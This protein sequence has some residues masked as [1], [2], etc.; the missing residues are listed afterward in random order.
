MALY[1]GMDRPA[2]DGAYNNAAAVA[3]SG[4]F[5]ADWKRRSAL[6]RERAWAHLNLPYG[7]APSAKIDFF[8]AG[9]P[10]AATLLFFHG[11]YWQSNSREGFAFVAE[12][13]LAH[14]INVAVVGYTL[15]PEARMDRIV[16][17]ARAAACWLRAHLGEL[18]GDPARL[19]ASG[20]SAGGHLAVTVMSDRAACGGLAISG[21]YDLEPIRLNYLNDKLGLD[22]AE[23]ERNSPLLHLP[24]KAGPLLIAVGGDELPEL[25][26][27][28]RDFAAAWVARGLPGSFRE[29]PGRHH[30]SVLEELA[31]P[32]GI[33]TRALV[34][35]VG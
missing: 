7:P 3:A 19:F 27:Q 18:G 32:G 15:A 6:M 9:R 1:R 35:L 28:S 5:L 34:D 26:R 11:G 33:L 31:R 25:R 17:E 21:I 12:G 22:A 16:R 4:D 30:F 20:W 24:T 23:A 14:G 13:P 10:G 8:G 29:T 2:L